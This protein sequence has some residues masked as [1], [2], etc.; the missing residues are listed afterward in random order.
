MTAWA[1]LPA[2]LLMGGTAAASA[3]ASAWR[4]PAALV[5]PLAY[6][7][8][9]CSVAGYAA[10]AWAAARL[11]ASQVASFTVLQPFLGTA[12]AA[13]FLGERLSPWDAGAVGVLAGLALVIR[14]DAGG[15]GGGGGGG[16]KGGVGGGVLGRTASG[17]GGSASGKLPPLSPV[18]PGPAR[19]A[20]A[21]GPAGKGVGWGFWLGRKPAVA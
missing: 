7:V 20:P 21:A 1:Y 15:G 5:G 19:P 11:P 12:L 6:W 10:V 3:P 14:A 16:E 8:L 9:V 17:L 13:G 4:L 18:L 2:A